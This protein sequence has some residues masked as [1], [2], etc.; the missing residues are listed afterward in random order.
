VSPFLC[1]IALSVLIA[2]P[3]GVFAGR[4]TAGEAEAAGSA[5]PMFDRNVTLLDVGSLDGGPQDDSNMLL[6]PMIADPIRPLNR[7]S[8]V[9]TKQLVDYVGLPLARGWCFVLRE[10]VREGV[11]NIGYNWSM[12]VRA[13]GLLLQGRFADTGRELQYFGVNTTLGV[14]G[15]RDAA[16]AR[17]MVTYGEDI[18]QAM[19]AGG[20]GPG[21]YVFVPVL[22]PSS[23][24]DLVGRVGDYLLNPET[25]VSGLSVV[26]GFNTFASRSDAYRRFRESQ[27]DL[28]LPIRALW[29]VQREADVREYVIPESAWSSADPEPSLGVLMVHPH[30]SAFAARAKVE[31]VRS[32]RTGRKVPYSLWLNE[33]ESPLVVIIP[34]IGAHRTSALSLVLAEEARG[35]GYS[36]V[37]LSNPFHP[38]FIRTGLS[39]RYPGYTPSDA[40]DLRR[41]I[42]ALRE[43]L[44]V[45]PAS[46]HLLGYSLGGLESLHIAA[47]ESD[48]LVF[49][50]CVAV[51]P[52]VDLLYSVSAFDGYFR[53]PTAWQG[54]DRR[55]RLEELALRL[56]AVLSEPDT[57]HRGLPFTREESELVVALKSRYTAWTA[58]TACEGKPPSPGEHR[59]P[60][61]VWNT[62]SFQGYVNRRLL[63]SVTG[64]GDDLRTLQERAGLHSVAGALADPRVRVI[65]N[66]DDFI[67]AP[68]HVEWLREKLGSRLHLNDHGGHLGNLHLEETR[69]TVFQALSGDRSSR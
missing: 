37:A 51:N 43:R 46:L 56:S 34:G 48:G 54:Q 16:K 3:V 42:A 4:A 2:G 31:R 27:A 39:A 28:Y 45:Q 11:G 1:R 67:L 29:T 18:G 61:M 17:K 26:F 22:G 12:P 69:K 52:P 19:G 64:D 25:Y 32:P 6:Q 57:Q 63:P 10:P 59:D 62:L 60:L 58:I 66:R 8:F 50:S 5:R 41:V 55:G 33:P 38:E 21:C 35:R 40:I 9:I 23:A 65:T 68:E 24:R 44:P 53:E 7:L 30:D 47:D 13:A 20:I 36:V 15:I 49:D 14:L